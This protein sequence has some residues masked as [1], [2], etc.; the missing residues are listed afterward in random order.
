[1]RLRPDKR[2]ALALLFIV[3]FS[4]VGFRVGWIAGASDAI[5]NATY[6]AGT[7]VSTASYTIF[8]VG[9][10]IYSKNGKTGA[11]DY[12]S[13][14]VSMV[15]LSSI[16]ALPPEGGIIHFDTGTYTF[17]KNI[18]F[19]GHQCLTIEGSGNGVE[20]ENTIFNYTG[21]GD[22]F[23]FDSQH[24]VVL[25]NF[26]LI[27]T[28]AADKG[29]DIEDTTLTCWNFV[30]DHVKV[31]GFG[32]NQ[33]FA[34][35]LWGST[36]QD[37]WFYGGNDTL[38]YLSNWCFQNT[39]INT[40]F[41]N[42]PDGYFGL[43]N[44]GILLTVIG[45]ECSSDAKGHG[46]GMGLEGTGPA[47]IQGMN[48]E[49]LNEGIMIGVASAGL[50]I[51]GE[52]T[53]QSCF[54]TTLTLAI[55]VGDLDSNSRVIKLTGNDFRYDVGLAVDYTLKCTAEGIMKIDNWMQYNFLNKTFDATTRSR[56][57]RMIVGTAHIAASDAIAVSISPP[58]WGTPTHVF[59]TSRTLGCGSIQATYFGSDY[60]EIH[61]DNI[62]TFDFQW[63]AVFYVDG[64]LM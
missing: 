26:A 13:N 21:T 25:R 24:D 56:I 57:P 53:I 28:S 14:N 2:I 36:I 22:A 60:F 44:H 12:S 16:A 19:T 23:R 33:L 63:I 51:Y 55:D 52:C 6:Q 29:I 31:S 64:Y 48:F 39:I 7:Q 41:T 17:N 38:V 32:G 59:V 34:S 11:I 42:I 18:D 15:I 35:N 43:R 37:C 3:C 4:I 10:T 5:N 1:M 20:A 47:L 9:S 45:G 8:Q 46:Y 50:S 62:G 61:T 27:G 40:K 49:R 30:F 58:I 54:F